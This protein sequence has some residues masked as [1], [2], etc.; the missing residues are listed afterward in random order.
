MARKGEELSVGEWQKIALVRAFIRNAEIVILDEPTSSLDAKAEFK[1]FELFQQMTADKMAIFISHRLA[2]ARFAD[3][4][5]V[6]EK[7]RIVENGAHDE[8]M[9]LNGAYARLHNLQAQNYHE[10]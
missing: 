3:R 8:L 6:L 4:I 10:R 7:C 5:L 2:S 1:I 9:R